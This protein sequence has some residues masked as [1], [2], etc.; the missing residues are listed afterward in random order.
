[1]ETTRPPHA[2]T[3]GAISTLAQRHLWGVAPSCN[4]QLCANSSHRVITIGRWGSQRPGHRPR[5]R[6]PFHAR[7]RRA[8]ARKIRPARNGGTAAVTQPAQ[9]TTRRLPGRRHRQSCLQFTRSCP[10]CHSRGQRRPP[11]NDRERRRSAAVSSPQASGQGQPRCNRQGRPLGPP[12]APVPSHERATTPNALRSSR[13]RRTILASAGPPSA[14]HPHRAVTSRRQRATPS[15]VRAAPMLRLARSRVVAHLG[16]PHRRRRP[17]QTRPRLSR[18][19]SSHHP[20]GRTLVTPAAFLAVAFVREL[21]MDRLDFDDKATLSVPY[22]VFFS[23]CG[24]W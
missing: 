23:G 22:H 9:S 16:L 24:P 20:D 17:R 13:G 11:A 10:P 7:Q 4:F 3:Y 19:R 5:C 6:A 12:T 15:S 1:M 21:F 2:Q 8:G 14:T 18:C